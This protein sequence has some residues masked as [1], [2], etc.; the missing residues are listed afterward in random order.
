MVAEDGRSR[1]ELE[2]NGERRAL[3]V[4]HRDSL[5]DVL[6]E[7]LD[8]TGAKR[9]CDRGECGACTVL[10]DERP[11]LACHLLALQVRDKAITTV[12]GLA[13]RPDFATVL[14]AFVA[15]DGGQCGFCVPGFAV[16]TYAALKHDPTLD[17]TALRW[18]L[19][20][21]V[22]RCNAYDRIAAAANEAAARIR[23]AG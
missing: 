16:A 22:C 10:V 8:L 6:R 18:E 12:E 19:V 3:D 23:G 7:D 14:D 13:E 20:G 17:E 11:M 2:V 5:L 15:E 1:I 21:H 9:A 4:E